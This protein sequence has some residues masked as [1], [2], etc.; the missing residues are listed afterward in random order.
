MK[1]CI[2]IDPTWLERNPLNRL[3][4]SETFWLALMIQAYFANSLVAFQDGVPKE[5]GAVRWNRHLPD[6]QEKA[7]KED[8]PILILFQEVPG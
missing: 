6:V 4:K 7:K 1:G 8:K 3:Q 5:L 2:I